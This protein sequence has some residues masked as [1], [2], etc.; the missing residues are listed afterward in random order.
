M[1]LKNIL[2]SAAG[3][4][5][6]VP[7][8]A[9]ADIAPSGGDDSA[10][11]QA[12]INA[13]G[14]GGTVTLAAGTFLL[15]SQLTVNNRVTLV[16]QGRDA[17]VLKYAGTADL[18]KSRVVTVEG[19][20]VLS[21]VAVTGGKVG[22]NYK[23]GGGV[24]I[25]GCGTVTWC[26]VTNNYARKGEGGGIGV[27][28]V[29]SSLPSEARIDHTIV[30][31]NACGLSNY[32]DMG[33]GI[34]IY[35]SSVRMN[36]VVIDSC[37]VYGN[38]AGTATQVGHG[39]GIG[40]KG[41]AYDMMS[42]EIRNTTIVDNS[43][44]GKGGGL[45]IPFAPQSKAPEKGR[46][47]VSNSI[48]ARNSAGTTDTVAAFANLAVPDASTRTAVSGNVSYCFFGLEAEAIGTGASFG[49]AAFEDPEAGD[50][51]L[52]D[53]LKLGFVSTEDLVDLDGN[54]RAEEPDAGCYEF[55]GVAPTVV[56]T[57]TL[58]PAA[59]T[60][61]PTMDV[62]IACRTRDATIYYT[63]DGSTPTTASTVYAGPITLTATTTV[64]AFACK[65]DLTPS[66]VAS[67][68]YVYEKPLQPIVLGETTV[69]PSTD[70]NGSAVKVAFTG[71]FPAGAAVSA[72]L[73][74]G[75]TECAG[76]VG[77][78]EIVFAVA[79][80]VATAGNTYD[81]TVTLSVG[82][83]TYTK[84]VVLTQGT[85]KREENASWIAE[86]ANAFNAT[87]AW[88]GE[89]ASVSSGKIAVS[90]ATFTASK[91]SAAGAKVTISTTL[92]FNGPSDVALDPAARAG[93]QV[94]KAAGVN[95]YA[96]LTGNG[97][98]TNTAFTANV[99]GTVSVKVELDY[100]KNEVVYTVGGTVYGPFAAT[101]G[102]KSVASARYVGETS[103]ATLD[104]AY[105]LEEL[106]T[107]V[108]KVGEVEYATVAEALAAG[109]G[110]VQLLWDSA[111]NPSAEGDYTFDKN[112]FNLVIGGP[113]AY[114]VKDNGDG[115]VTVTVGGSV[116]PEA[117]APTSVTMAGDS[118]KIG[119]ENL[120]SD[121]WYA[122]EK[123]TDLTKPFVI[124]TTTW[125]K[126]SEIIG[127]TKELVIALYGTE[128]Q[129][130]Y[131]VVVSTTAP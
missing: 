45:Y 50:Y 116:E 35:S 94:V 15:N 128:P 1:K 121:L 46:V 5:V 118:V 95:R 60:F 73:A 110:Q 29:A 120:K 66:D 92:V 101:A 106:D 62:T 125:T 83:K 25:N 23:G 74:I 19:Y 109:Q 130:F 6:L 64:K 14:E 10:T 112:G 27:L 40:F 34:G 99:S 24:L 65:T 113:L 8:F 123:T 32:E 31:D 87:G 114:S 122:L 75:G 18:E 4:L 98:V 2:A 9:R 86:S 22:G 115:T 21:S 12:A 96:F 127:G 57:P 104:G 49:T 37:L 47:A 55:N 100:A 48:L 67:A 13:A 7:T 54:N 105:R 91:P 111:W 97:V 88:S 26:C 107:N 41:S 68:T 93:V 53:A 52:G 39:G 102:A 30:A 84:S 76:T 59:C 103:V 61:Y 85:V 108:A 129:A 79:D 28:G 78:E 77:E 36:S 124:D 90:N 16:G 11:I 20:G 56:M 33:G 71:D 81:A 43:A 69:R 42:A 70:Y 126:G 72:K 131:R 44:T 17:T 38:R 117:P 51:H 80:S 3:L 58:A 89:K 63:L 82:D 119:V